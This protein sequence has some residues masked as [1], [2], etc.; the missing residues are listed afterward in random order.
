MI[1]SSVE[2]KASPQVELFPVCVNTVF[3]LDV[4]TVQ[5]L[6]TDGICRTPL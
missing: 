5:A 2:L 3:E 1:I 6:N 4:E